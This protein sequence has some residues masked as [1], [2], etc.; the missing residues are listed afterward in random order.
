MI[1]HIWNITKKSCYNEP[2]KHL[3]CNSFIKT[4]SYDKLYEQ[5]KN[6]DHLSWRQFIDHNKVKILFHDDFIQQPTTDKSQ[7]YVGYWFFK[8]R[9]DFSVKGNVYLKNNK[10]E[11]MLRYVGNAILII[12]TNNSFEI[13]NRKNSLMLRPF[14]EV[15]FSA[16]TIDRIKT[17]LN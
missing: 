8:Q 3:Y 2:I 13:G 11:K 14:C 7:P 1:H 6:A 5:W 9:T 15:Y 16:E 17:L 10:S 12:E 4:D